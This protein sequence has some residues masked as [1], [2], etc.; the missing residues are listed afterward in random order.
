MMAAASEPQRLCATSA[1]SRHAKQYRKCVARE[2]RI[3]ELGLPWNDC[4]S[5]PLCLVQHSIVVAGVVGQ[6][7]GAGSRLKGSSGDTV[8]K[9]ERRCAQCRI[10]A[11]PR[12]VPVPGGIRDRAQWS[13]CAS[14]ATG[15]FLCQ[16]AASAS[17]PACV[18]VRRIDS[19]TCGAASKRTVECNCPL[20]FAL[21]KLLKPAV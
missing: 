6:T 20:S 16:S 21:S 14:K 2:I 19:T 18:A 17:H 13:I 9:R 5:N 11:I 10:G 7:I 8:P 4:H 12:T 3:I 15:L 1:P